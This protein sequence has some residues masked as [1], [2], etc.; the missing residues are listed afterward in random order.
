MVNPRVLV[1]GAHPDDADLLTG[2]TTLRLVKSGARVR[3]ISACNGDKG[4]QTNWG[5]PLAKRRQAEAKASSKLLGVEEYVVLDHPDC[6]LEVTMDLKR[7]LTRLVRAFA[8]HYIL[9]HRMCDYHSDHRAVSTALTDIAYFLGVPGWCPGIPVPD[10]RPVVLFVRDTFTVPRE[11]RPDIIVPA[12]DPDLLSRYYE[13]LACHVSQFSEWLPFER[14]IVAECPD[15]TDV[16]AR[17]EFLE[18]HWVKVRKGYDAQRF[19]VP[20][21]KYVEVFEISEYGR[22]PSSAELVETFGADIVL[23]NRNWVQSR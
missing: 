21:L 6:E 10:V 22:Q 15:W 16:H 17:A 8:P 20:D 18:K 5:E 11:L 13:A 4:H 19:G 14:N 9:T 23:R 2:V 7:E 3:Y 1:V 12:N